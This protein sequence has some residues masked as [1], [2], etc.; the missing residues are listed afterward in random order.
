MLVDDFGD[1]FRFYRDELGLEPSFGDEPPYASFAASDA[2]V[3]IFE[4]AGQAETVA[5][6]PTGDS[7]LRVLD[8]E[9]V[10]AQAAR[11]EARIV[12]PPVDSPDWGG[13]VAYVRDPSGNLI[14]LFQQIPMSE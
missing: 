5:L 11:L 13:R 9:D 8:V 4:R 1:A 10:D 6:R 7:V 12:G 14:E 2:S 3:A